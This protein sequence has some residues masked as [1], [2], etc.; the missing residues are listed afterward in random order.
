L[1]I[2][3]AYKKVK[4]FDADFKEL[5]EQIR[6]NRVKDCDKALGVTFSNLEK[7]IK[8]LE[9]QN[10][11]VGQVQLDQKKLKTSKFED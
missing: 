7:L 9:K 6:N 5:E 4:D 11:D 1:L 3:E 8:L 10:K 2:K